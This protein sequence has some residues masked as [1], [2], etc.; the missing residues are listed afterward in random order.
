M[1]LENL[2]SR[3]R[4]VEERNKR[5]EADKAWET[6]YARMF[7]LGVIT[8]TI[9]VIFLIMTALP[10]PFLSALIP[11]IGFMLSVQ[12]IPTVKKWWLTKKRSDQKT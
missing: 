7:L 8:Y 1:K 5:V 6:S 12:T 11:A 9:A 3:I 2:E 10:F 4:A